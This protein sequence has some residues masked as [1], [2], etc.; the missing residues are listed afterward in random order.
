MYHTEHSIAWHGMASYRM[1]W[2]GNVVQTRL[3]L[4]WKTNTDMESFSPCHS[5]S[6]YIF[7]F[8]CTMERMWASERR[9]RPNNDYVCDNDGIGHAANTLWNAAGHK[10]SPGWASFEE[11]V[12]VFFQL[13]MKTYNILYFHGCHSMD[14]CARAKAKC[15][16]GLVLCATGHSHSS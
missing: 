15:A 5:S 7:F 4:E 13:E 8:C 9:R 1:A 11:E 14:Q 12:N 10:H 6:I 3:R 16:Y 2:H